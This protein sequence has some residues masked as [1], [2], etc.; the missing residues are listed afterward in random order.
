MA[1]NNYDPVTLIANWSEDRALPLRSGGVIADYGDRKFSTVS[2]DAFPEK[3]QVSKSRPQLL[4]ASASSSTSNGRGAYAMNGINYW[5]DASKER[6]TSE[7]KPSF[8]S[9]IP[10]LKPGH[11]NSPSTWRTVHQVAYG[12]GD[13]PRTRMEKSATMRSKD[14]PWVYGR[15]GAR[16]EKGMKTS[17]AIGEVFKE[18]DNP[19]MNTAC[20]RSWLYSEDPMLEAKRV[21]IEQPPIEMTC[22]IRGPGERELTKYDP[23]GE[24]KRSSSITKHLD[25]K[26]VPVRG[27]RVFKD[28]D[29]AIV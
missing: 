28:Q 5:E 3:K 27:V 22:S 6:E 10:H 29:D 13:S 8:L 7:T 21:N 11:D 18:C 15:G 14:A 26:G 20:Q 2:R 4:A 1:T 23:E 17:G 25:A 16:V 24:Y 9:V 12:V 19:Q